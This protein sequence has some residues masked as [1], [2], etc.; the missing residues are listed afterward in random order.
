MKIRILLIFILSY[1][2][3][4]QV[5][6]TIDPATTYQT[7]VG[8]E[9]HGN[10]PR[11]FPPTYQQVSDQIFDLLVEVGVNRVQ[12]VF[13][14]GIENTQDFWQMVEDSLIPYNPDFRE[15]RYTT[16]NDNNDPNVINW[17][18]FHFTET[19]RTLDNVVLPIKQRVE[20]NGESLW[21]SGVYVA[22]T[23]QNRSGTQY[24]HDD[25]NEYAEF[26]LACY[27]WMDNTYGF[28][29]DSWEIILE[30]DNGATL[31]WNKNMMGAAIVAA[32]NKL[33][34]HGY[35]A[36]FVIP[37]TL[38][39]GEAW[40]YFDTIIQTPGVLNYIGEL[41]YHRYSGA[42]LTNLQNIANRAEQHGLKTFMSEWWHQNND[43]QTLHEDLTTGINSSWQKGIAAGQPTSKQAF[44]IVDDSNP[45]NP[46]VSLHPKTKM[47]RQYFKKVRRG[48]AR[49]DATST[50][51][52]F[53]PL[54][55]INT[56]GTYVVVI[57]AD[58]NATFDIVGLPAGQ[59]GIFYTTN[60]QYDVHL[61]DVTIN[62]GETLT[63][64]IPAAG[65]ITVYGITST[66]ITP[67]QTPANL[68]V[69]K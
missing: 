19:K 36:N 38:S 30:P 24:H 43:Y 47:M 66:D 27:Q 21:I 23:A 25:P 53:D 55:F 37:S 65:V 59:Y 50:S 33:E 54:A 48:A 18:G 15:L 61:N 51:G 67:P 2:G 12:L 17:N 11:D 20:A 28:V 64:S 58:N 29:P 7:M 57:K 4:A 35:T 9:A 8:W 14:A 69:L 52:S 62:T 44:V 34:Q 40:K 3:F 22:F 16:I 26:V 46:I 63:T 68:K 31:Q 1:A 6:I 10:S 13:R 56:N 60:S 45:N 42:N 49:I 41:S 5:T 39:M 32:G